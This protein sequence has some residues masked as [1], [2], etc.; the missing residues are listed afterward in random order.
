MALEDDKP[1]GLF[2]TFFP[3]ALS[4]P[5]WNWRTALDQPLRTLYGDKAGA[6]V[7]VLVVGFCSVTRRVF[8]RGLAP[9]NDPAYSRPIT[10]ISSSL[11]LYKRLQGRSTKM[12]MILEVKTDIALGA[13]A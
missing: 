4:T 12:S 11:Y 8:I 2:R 5:N 1:D 3:D 9:A 6:T 13:K 10:R 7:V